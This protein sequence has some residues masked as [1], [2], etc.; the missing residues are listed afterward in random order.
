MEYTA[1]EFVEKHAGKKH[2]PYRLKH[3]LYHQH[4]VI[5]CEI[6]SGRAAEHD[7]T[8][9]AT[10]TEADVEKL[11]R[12]MSVMKEDVLNNLTDDEEE[13]ETTSQYMGI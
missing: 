9:V 6:L 5:H 3:L 12:Q 11:K 7:M 13:E 8:R 4:F 10:L 2:F 1:Q